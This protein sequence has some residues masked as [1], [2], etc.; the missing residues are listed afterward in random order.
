MAEAVKKAV[1]LVGRRVVKAAKT[2]RKPEN[3]IPTL[4]LG[5][6]AFFTRSPKPP[7]RATSI[8]AGTSCAKK[9]IS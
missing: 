9:L 3:V 2:L 4:G 6:I 5:A 1:V 7:K 8:S